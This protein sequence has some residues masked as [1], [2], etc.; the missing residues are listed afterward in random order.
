MSLHN[1]NAYGLLLGKC[2]FYIHDTNRKQSSM[3]YDS[4]MCS[5]ID[6]DGAM[7]SEPMKEP[8]GAVMDRGRRRK[9]TCVKGSGRECVIAV[10]IFGT[11]LRFLRLCVRNNAGNVTGC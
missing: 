11:T 9:E 6:V 5:F 4:D 7:G 2:P 10:N 3:I 8:E 1:D